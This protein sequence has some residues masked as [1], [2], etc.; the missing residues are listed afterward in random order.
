MRRGLHSSLG[1]GIKISNTAKGLL[2]GKRL[3]PTALDST[4]MPLGQ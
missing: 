4:K 3:Q 2:L 1:V